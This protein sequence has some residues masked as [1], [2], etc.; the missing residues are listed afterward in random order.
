MVH[1]HAEAQRSDF[2]RFGYAALG[3]P[4]DNLENWAIPFVENKEPE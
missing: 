2:Y 4:L 1:T 3:F